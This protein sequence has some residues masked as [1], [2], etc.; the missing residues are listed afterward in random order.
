MKK[1]DKLILSKAFDQF[2]NENNYCLESSNWN[3]Q[4]Y[5][6]PIM[7]PTDRTFDSQKE[8]FLFKDKLNQFQYKDKVFYFANFIF[9]HE[10][11]KSIGLRFLIEKTPSIDSRDYHEIVPK[12]V[13]ILKKQGNDFFD[14]ISRPVY[15]KSNRN[16][17]IEFFKDGLL[18]QAEREAI[19]EVYLHL[20]NFSEL[21]NK[22]VIYEMVE[23]YI[24][25]REKYQDYFVDL[26]ESKNK[27]ENTNLVYQ[28]HKCEMY[29]TTIELNELIRMSPTTSENELIT[30]LNALEYLPELC[31]KLGLEKIVT[32]KPKTKENLDGKS[33]EVNWL[34]QKIDENLVNYFINAYLKE[35]LVNP[36][37]RQA[38]YEIDTKFSSKVNTFVQDCISSARAG[39]LHDKIETMLPKNN[40]PLNKKKKI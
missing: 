16:N 39:A 28:A 24:N 37:L 22:V 33:I 6:K 11:Y 36:D 34:S 1:T 13:E 14:Y 9:D 29:S 23:K 38:I 40:I 35:L 20:D 32:Q 2:C 12:I 17:I 3:G 18:S 15:L 7:K 5:L 21:K 10:E 8:Q 31:E 26:H 30:A 19:V 27:I 4:L 25:N